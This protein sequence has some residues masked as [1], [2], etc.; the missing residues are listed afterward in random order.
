[1]QNSDRFYM[2]KFD[3]DA[4]VFNSQETKRRALSQL[5]KSEYNLALNNCEH[6]AMWCKTGGNTS[7]QVAFV[8]NHS[9]R[10]YFDYPF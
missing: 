9:K 8:Q 10:I 3:K 1:M 6:F 2:L 5:G 7:D 4:D